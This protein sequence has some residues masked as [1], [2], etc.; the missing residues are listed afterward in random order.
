V[1]KDRNVWILRAIVPIVV[2]VVI[3]LIPAPSGLTRNAW[4]FFALFAAVIGAVI[5]EP[6]PAA[7]VGLLGIV[8]AAAAGLVFTATS[9]SIGW[10]LSGFSNTTVWLIFGAYMFALGYAKTGL[11][12]RISL[13]LIKALGKRTLGLGYAIFVADLVLAPFTPSN[14]ARTGGTIYP[15]IRNIPELYD[16][17]PGD[18]SA[19]KLGSYI[20]YTA[21]AAT[22]VTSGMFLTAMAPNVLAVGLM[23]SL[24]KVTVQWLAW[25]WGFLPVGI[26]L[27][28]VTPFLVYKLYPPEIKVSPE[29]PNWASEELKKMGKVTGKEIA[30]V[31]L[32]ILALALWIGA[33]QYLDSSLVALLVVILMVILKIVNWDDILGYKQA[34]N[35]FIWFATLVT[36]ADGLA[37]VKFI[38]WVTSL[39]APAVKGL[40]LYSA[41]VLMAAAFFLIHYFFASGTAHITALFP[42]FFA[43]AVT[44]PGV[45]PVTWGLLLAYT[46]GL[47]PMMTPYSSGPSPIYY[48]SGYIKPRDFWLYGTIFSLIFLGTYLIIG[49]PWLLS[50]NL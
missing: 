7:A 36:M 14:T 22:S 39:V 13:R 11:G 32:V 34:Y 49:I 38:D 35:V 18:A 6:I 24:R 12:K 42:A 27:F 41:V 16:S 37:R 44:I 23:G 25:F 10:A 29:A 47:T 15:I 30:L 9:Q 19:R 26:I 20:M 2:G 45:S 40:P 31:L 8:I 17:H 4:Y 43:I 1:S 3:A 48:G 5:T 46:V 28:L 50:L 33:A 21:L